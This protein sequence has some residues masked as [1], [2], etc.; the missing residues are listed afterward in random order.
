MRSALHAVRRLEKDL[1]EAVEERPKLADAEDDLVALRRPLRAEHIAV[2]LLVDD[3]RAS[4]YGGRHQE[5]CAERTWRGAAVGDELAAG[6]TERRQVRA[7]QAD[8]V[9]RVAAKC[10]LECRQRHGKTLLKNDVPAVGRP[11]SRPYVP[12]WSPFAVQVVDTSARIGLI[13]AYIA[14]V[15][16][17]K[18][19]RVH[20]HAGTSG[21]IGGDAGG[22]VDRHQPRVVAGLGVCHAIRQRLLRRHA[23]RHYVAAVSHPFRASAEV[24]AFC[25]FLQPGAVRANDVDIR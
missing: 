21:E 10:F 17:R 1:A 16:S 23:I 11:R 6:G 18:W 3:F 25:D 13:L 12:P 4:G 20:F 2:L 22:R 8:F 15:V 5:T 24:S 9:V 19:G 7:C 14:D